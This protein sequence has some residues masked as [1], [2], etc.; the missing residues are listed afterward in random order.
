MTEQVNNHSEK[1]PP[2][3]D[4]HSLLDMIEGSNGEACRQMLADH[5]EKFLAAAGSSHNH[6][7]WPGGYIDH[8]TDAMNIGLSVYELYQSMRPLPFTASDVLLIVYLHDLEKPFKYTYDTDGNMQQDSRFPDK[9]SGELFKR[10]MIAQYGIVLNDMQD[11]A[12]EF[13]EG[14]RDPKYQRSRRVMGELAVVCHIAD[15]TSAR[16]WFNNPSSNDDPWSG[17]ERQNRAAQG[18]DLP[19]EFLSHMST[20]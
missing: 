2:Y 8:V 17:A 5:E 16:L 11:N 10:N 1:Q 9:A 14:I 4:L 15:L 3:Y 19:S 13:V 18:I 20:R 6:Q 12:L 7:A